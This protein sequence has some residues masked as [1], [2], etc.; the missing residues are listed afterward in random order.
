MNI[1]ALKALREPLT[2][3]GGGAAMLFIDPANVSYL[4]SYPCRD[5]FLLDSAKECFYFTDFRYLED[6]S[7]AF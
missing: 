5:S 1:P 3:C 2:A 7:R 6:V 4:C